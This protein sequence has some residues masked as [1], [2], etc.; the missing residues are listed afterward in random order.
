MVLFNIKFNATVSLN[1][2]IIARA[3]TSKQ[4]AQLLRENVIPS[5]KIFIDT[6]T[7][8]NGFPSFIETE[9]YSLVNKTKDFTKNELHTPHAAYF[10]L[11]SY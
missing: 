4:Y 7:D 2:I 1:F 10:Y 9:N 8:K 6:E 3:K 11:A 5:S